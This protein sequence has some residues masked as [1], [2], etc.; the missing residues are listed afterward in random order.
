MF[1]DMIILNS[2]GF[3]IMLLNSVLHNCKVSVLIINLKMRRKS[4]SKLSQ[5]LC[6][7]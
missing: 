5:T 1:W 3:K 4:L 2:G 6:F 7:S